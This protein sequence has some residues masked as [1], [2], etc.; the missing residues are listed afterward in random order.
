MSKD[1]QKLTKAELIQEIKELKMQLEEEIKYNNEEFLV[2]FPWAGNLG[3]WKWF[4]DENKVIFNEK[5]VTQLGYDPKVIGEVGFQFFTEKLHPNDYEGVMD[6]MRNH[7]MGKT[8]AYEVEYRIQ[9][10]DGHYIW[11][12]DRGTVTKRDSLGKTQIIQGIVFDIS[13]S[14]RVEQRLRDLSEKDALTEIYNRRTFYVKVEELIELCNN[15]KTPFSLVMFDIDNFKYINDTYGHLVGDDVL[16]IIT[17][18]INDDKRHKDQIFRFGGEE[19]FL[20]LPNTKMDGAIKVANRI[21]EM[22]G[23]LNMPKVGKVTVSMG[24]VEYIENESIDNSIKRVD[25]LMYAA[26]KLGK[27]QVVY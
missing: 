3:Q 9:H 7:L 13:E 22:I 11:Y 24:V 2:Q 23:N 17:E 6:N 27:N 15:K 18:L 10:K 20:V 25:D 8:G 5:K 16:K 26:K 4:Y 19:F 21:H 1:Y 12:Y 14:K